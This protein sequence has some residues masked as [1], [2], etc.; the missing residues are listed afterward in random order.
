L[1]D[2]EPIGVD[3]LPEHVRVGRVETSSI[4]QQVLRQEKTLT[5]AVDSSIRN[6]EVRGASTACATRVLIGVTWLTTA[7]VPPATDQT[8]APAQQQQAV[9]TTPQTTPV[10]PQATTPAP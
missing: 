5:D 7:T 9:P 2:H 4:Q 6:S 10:Q 1:S 8:P 3:D